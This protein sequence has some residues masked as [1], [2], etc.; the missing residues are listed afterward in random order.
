MKWLIILVVLLVAF[1]FYPQLNESASTSCAATEKRFARAAFDPKD[2]GSVLGALLVSGVSNGALA[3]EFAKNRYP[4]IPATVGCVV[5][6]YQMMVDPEMPKR[7]M[8]GR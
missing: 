7:A 3:S 8:E 1:F 2:G 6:Y 4:N 5:V